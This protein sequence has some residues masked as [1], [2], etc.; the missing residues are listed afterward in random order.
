MKLAATIA[1][2]LQADMQVELRNIER[3][4]A[5]GTRDAGRGLKTELRRQVAAPGSVSGSPTAGATSTTRTQG[6]LLPGWP[7]LARRC[8]GAA[9]AGS[10]HN[11]SG[12]TRNARCVARRNR[13]AAGSFSSTAGVSSEATICDCKL[14]ASDWH[15]KSIGRA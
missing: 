5:A 9:G 2:A 13:C 14:E 3:A 15:L 1:R 4:V 7:P 11:R 8:S 6:S 10:R 12:R